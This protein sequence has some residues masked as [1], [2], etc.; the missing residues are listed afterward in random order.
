[1]RNRRLVAVVLSIS[2][3]A[4]VSY[5][6]YAAVLGPGG[7]IK[8]C[9]SNTNV[10][11]QHAI[12]LTDGACPSGMTAIT[13][14]QQGPKGDPGPEGPPGPSGPQGLPGATGPSGATGATG[15]Q[16]SPGAN[17]NTMLNGSGAPTNE[18]GN[19]GDFYIDTNVQILYGP[20]TPNGWNGTVVNLV[21]P[22][23][24]VGPTGPEGPPG[25]STADYSGLDVV[26]ISGGGGFVALVICPTDR[27]I[28]L[29]GGGSTG[30]GGHLQTSIPWPDV[31]V[32][33]GWLAIGDGAAGTTA[34]VICS[35]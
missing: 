18:L 22:Q 24:V 9:Y 12:T 32:P 6:A 5:T 23:G 30:E 27:P 1:M 29:G 19:V 15:P 4:A 20:K 25:P 26:I 34:H 10:Q 21:G 2:G 13:W 8:A 11:G 33:H 31:G 16:G 28:A 7:V 17:G 14:N 35:K 3:I